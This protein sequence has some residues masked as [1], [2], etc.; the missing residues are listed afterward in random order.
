MTDNLTSDELNLIIK[1]AFKNYK[2]PLYSPFRKRGNPFRGILL[3]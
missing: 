3:S 1:K 2:F